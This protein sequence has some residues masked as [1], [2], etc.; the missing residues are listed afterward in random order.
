MKQLFSILKFVLPYYNLIIFNTIFNCLA[1]LFSLFSISLVIPILSILFGTLEA[2]ENI[3]AELSLNNLKDFFYAHIHKLVENKG[4]LSALAFICTLVGIGAIL[5]N[6]TR[7][8]ALYCLTPIR[9]NVIRDIR[10]TLYSKLLALPLKAINKLKKGDI[11]ARMTSDLT[12]IEW[13]IMGV[14]EFFIKDPIHII[15]FLTSLIYISPELTLISFIFLPITGFI[16]TKISQSL[17]KQSLFSQHKI[18]ELMAIIEESISNVKII[19]ALNIYGFVSNTFN[20]E[21]ESLKNINNRVL[22]RKDLASPMSEMLSTLVMVIIIWIGGKLVLTSKLTP[23]YFIGFL[24]IFSQILPPTKSLTTA[25]YSLQKGM[26]AVDRVLIILNSKNQNTNQLKCVDI[27]HQDIVF[28]NVSF[29]YSNHVNLKDINLKIQKGHKIAIVGESGS[30]KSTLAELL[31]KLYTPT[32]GSIHVDNNNIKNIDVQ[33][34]FTVVTQEVML[35]NNSI[36]NNLA[37]GK[38]NASFD[39]ITNATKKAYIHNVINNLENRYD[40]LLGSKG[41]NLSGGERQ[42]IA[43]ARALLRN[44]PILIFDEPTSSLD[45]ESHNYIQKTFSKLNNKQTLIHITHKLQA[46]KEYDQIIVMK[47]GEIVEEGKHDFLIKNHGVYKKL[48]EIDTL[49]SHEKT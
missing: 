11:I 31:L 21:N 25:F 8:L 28:N 40:T 49:K 12:E 27:F 22:W 48:Y 35:F 47:N 41:N 4:L 13:S 9:N 15:I 38:V 36:K 14:L 44:S 2:P 18:G 46:I 1:V 23:D 24:V 10:K 29:K 42:R 6:T 19:K 20:N 32:H 16:I 33:S 43:I 5:K 17:K 34:L 26:G 45:V 39:E 30:G 37:M 7:Y 3:S